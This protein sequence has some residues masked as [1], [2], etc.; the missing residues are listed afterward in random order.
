MNSCLG[1]QHSQYFHFVS[2]WIEKQHKMVST[3]FFNTILLVCEGLLTSNKPYYW[4]TLVTTS[5]SIV[6]LDFDSALKSGDS[7]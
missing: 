3:V 4:E 2:W 1:K 5:H 7:F 6:I